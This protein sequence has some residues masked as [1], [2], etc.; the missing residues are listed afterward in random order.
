MVAGAAAG[1]VCVPPLVSISGAGPF[2]MLGASQPVLDS[3]GENDVYISGALIAVIRLVVGI[4]L[5][6]ALRRLRKPS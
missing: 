5:V 2:A 4:P 6:R 1:A 3:A